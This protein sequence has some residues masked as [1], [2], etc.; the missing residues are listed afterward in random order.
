MGMQPDALAETQVE[1]SVQEK[2]KPAANKP[3]AKTLVGQVLKGQYRIDSQ[4]GQGA[5]GVVFRGMQLALEKPVAI[6]MLRPD[7]F[8]GEDALD[9]FGREATVSS[10][11]NHPSIAQVLDFGVEADM[12]FLV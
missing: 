3:G 9:R 4:L 6:K 2:A 7:G 12:P 1:S 11:L 8:H 10:K 5:M